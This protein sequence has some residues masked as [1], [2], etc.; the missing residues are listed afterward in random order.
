MS[1]QCRYKRVHK[2]Y[3]RILK[4]CIKNFLT[5]HKLLLKGIRINKLTTIEFRGDLEAED[6]V[7][8]DSNV[9]FEGKVVLSKGVR[10]DS[11]CFLKDCTVGSNTHIRQNSILKGCKIGSNGIIGPYARIRP[12]SKIGKNT[13]IG[14]FVEVKNSYIGSNTKIN[15]LTYVGDSEIGDNVIIGAGSVTCNFDGH[16]THKTFIDDNVFIGSGVLL[17]APIN[18]GRSATIGSGSVI[19]QDVPPKKLTLARSKQI[20]IDNWKG[21]KKNNNT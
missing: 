21:P 20:T 3:L 19:T 5:S 14:N 10:I 6:D 13:Q 16:V 12:D 4:S 15:H 18:V 1:S 17:V 7:E 9:I 2:N 11:K 8:I